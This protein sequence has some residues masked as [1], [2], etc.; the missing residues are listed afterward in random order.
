[1]TRAYAKLNLLVGVACLVMGISVMAYSVQND[2]SWYPFIPTNDPSP[3]E[4]GMQA[5][6]DKPAG[7]YGRITREEDR[8]IYA[9]PLC[10]SICHGPGAG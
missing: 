7:Q 6:L 8:L 2:A 5:W 9:V 3:G 4:I 10:R 1:M